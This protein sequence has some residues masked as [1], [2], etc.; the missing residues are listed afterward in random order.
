MIY[1]T[2]WLYADTTCTGYLRVPILCHL[3]AR[4]RYLYKQTFAFLSASSIYP[5]SLTQVRPTPG[6]TGAPPRLGR[7]LPIS[8]PRAAS[9]HHPPHPSVTPTPRGPPPWRCPG[10]MGWSPAAF[11]TS[12]PAA[13]LLLPP[14]HAD[15]CAQLPFSLQHRLRHRMRLP[16]PL[17]FRHI[18]KG[19]QTP[20]RGARIRQTCAW[21][22]LRGY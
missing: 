7:H 18:R 6:P 1:Y 9:H 15:N 10:D 13:T 11:P 14:G 21:G 16:D 2:I 4:S 22:Q 5:W 17:P 12:Y 19:S 20:V 3:L 8:V